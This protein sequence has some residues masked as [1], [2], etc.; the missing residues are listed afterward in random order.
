LGAVSYAFGG[1]LAHKL[2]AGLPLL[3]QALGQIGAG[4]VIL[5]PLAGVDL[6]GS[7]PTHLPS[8]W[9]IG[10]ALALCWGGASPA[11]PLFFWLLEGVGPPRTAIVTY[12]RPCM[13]LVYGV[14]LLRE[15]LGLN[16][17]GGLSL[18]LM[19]VFLAG[20]PSSAKED[21]PAASASS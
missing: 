5:A 9:A 12:L 2:F 21:A 8:A 16:A 11:S 18:V 17:L 10:A 1:L 15:P 3:Q 13:A 14:L 20:K 19:G 4:A 6:A 7:P